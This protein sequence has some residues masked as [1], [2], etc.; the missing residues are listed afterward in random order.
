MNEVAERQAAQNEIA[1]LIK[2]VRTDPRANNRP[3]LGVNQIETMRAQNGGYPRDLYHQHLAPVTVLSLDEEQAVSAKGYVRNYIHQAYPAMRY[4]RNYS[5]KFEAA[6]FVETC[7]VSSKDEDAA[8]GKQP[9][10]ANCGLWC[11]NPNDLEPLPDAPAED[12]NVTIARLEGQLAE[13]RAASENGR[14]KRG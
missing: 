1:A 2:R 12:P 7:T 5:A 9:V 3:V 10:P 6:S 8:L 14:S 13:A 11:A 4:R